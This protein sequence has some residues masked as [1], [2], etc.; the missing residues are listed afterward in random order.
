MCALTVNGRGPLSGHCAA[1]D[2]L[3]ASGSRPPRQPGRAFAIA[4]DARLVNAY[5]WTGT[6][7][8][9]LSNAIDEDEAA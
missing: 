4:I 2:Q 6:G 7:Y 9:N 5:A 3:I 8:G 1:C